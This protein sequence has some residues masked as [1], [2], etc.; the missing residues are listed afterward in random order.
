MRRI[1]AAAA[2]LLAST[3]CTTMDRAEP[4]AATRM[5]APILTTPDAF[6]S[7][8][9]AQPQVARATHV[10]LDLALDFEAQRVGGTAD[11]T[12]L[13]R[14][15]AEQIVLDSDGLEIARVTDARGNELEW[16]VGEDDGDKGAPLTIQIGPSTGSGQAVRQIRIQYMAPADVQALQWLSP[17]QTAGGTHPF[18]FSQ[19]QAILNRS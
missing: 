1:V 6:D 7:L 14:P 9:Y 11:L 17:E 5:V 13:A 2:L 4:L 16:S 15:G 18:L 10:A 8:T 3:A 12:I 19:G